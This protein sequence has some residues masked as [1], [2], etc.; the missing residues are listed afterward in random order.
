MA[1][2]ASPVTV[3]SVARAWDL[4]AGQQIGR[5]V[6]VVDQDAEIFPV[7]FAVDGESIVIRTAEG[8]KLSAL[9][10]NHRVAFEVDT[11]DV[12]HGYSVI[13][14]GD[15]APITDPAELARAEALRLKPWVPTVKTIFVRIDADQ[16]S[17]RK[18]TF[19]PDPIEKFRY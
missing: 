18:F 10:R 9:L 5:L 8:T 16:I 17:A 15:A 13:L 6:V 3:L 2:S 11:W 12:D 1:E 7:N 4:L 19:G 14:H